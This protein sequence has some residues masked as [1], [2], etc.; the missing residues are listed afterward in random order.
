[1]LR[2]L[3]SWN[4]GYLGVVDSMGVRTIVLGFDDVVLDLVKTCVKVL[5]SGLCEVLHEVLHSELLVSNS[6]LK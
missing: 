3:T 2:H 4:Y 5:V 6:C 1:M